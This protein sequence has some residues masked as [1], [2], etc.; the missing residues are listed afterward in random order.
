MVCAPACCARA[1]VRICATL[2]CVHVTYKIYACDYILCV[3]ARACLYVG[4]TR[5]MWE[6]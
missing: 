2:A 1:L 5:A 4:E 6:S 3:H